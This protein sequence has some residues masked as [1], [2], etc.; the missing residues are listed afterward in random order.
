MSDVLKNNDL[1]GAALSF[2]WSVDNIDEKWQMLKS[3][4]GDLNLLL[5]NKL[6][7]INKSSQLLKLENT[8]RV[9]CSSD[10]DH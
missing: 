8:E 5:K 4:Y 7:E 6:S 1:E 2:V 10:P 3:A 9:V